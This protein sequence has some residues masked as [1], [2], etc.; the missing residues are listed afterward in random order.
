MHQKKEPAGKW[1][2]SVPIPL[3]EPHLEVASFAK[4]CASSLASLGKVVGSEELKRMKHCR[5]NYQKPLLFLVDGNWLG[6]FC[7]GCQKYWSLHV[8]WFLGKT[9]GKPLSCHGLRS[10]EKRQINTWNLNDKNNVEK[11]ACVVT[12]FFAWRE[13]TCFFKL[14][15]FEWLTAVTCLTYLISHA[16]R[17]ITHYGTFLIAFG[18]PM[19]GF[20]TKRAPVICSDMQHAPAQRWPAGVAAPAS[21]FETGCFS[22]IAASANNSWKSSSHV[23]YYKWNQ[24]KSQTQIDTFEPWQTGNWRASWQEAT[25]ITHTLHTDRFP[26]NALNRS[27]GSSISSGSKSSLLGAVPNWGYSNALYHK[28]KPLQPMPKHP[29]SG[30]TNPPENFLTV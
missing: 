20:K 1:N 30:S 8:P 14:S 16:P 6:Q 24:L 17:S 10:F 12:G 7:G 25:Q 15:A 5:I 11:S 29:K 27:S 26:T 18:P 13:S 23:F 21:L 2:K 19:L 3:G 28:G 9:L 22:Q 4:F